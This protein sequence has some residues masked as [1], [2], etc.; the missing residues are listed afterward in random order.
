MGQRLV[1]LGMTKTYRK[2]IS[3]SEEPHNETTDKKSLA[4][5]SRPVL[6]HFSVYDYNYLYH[7]WRSQNLVVSLIIVLVQFLTERKAKGSRS[8]GGILAGIM[9]TSFW[10]SSTTSTS[11]VGT[12]LNL[13]SSV[14]RLPGA[15]RSL[16]FLIGCSYRHKRYLQ[17]VLF[18]AVDFPHGWT[19]K[20]RY[21]MELHMHVII[22]MWATFLPE[23]AK[24]NIHTSKEC[25]DENY[26]CLLAISAERSA[27]HVNVHVFLFFLGS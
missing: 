18:L 13:T 25:T 26:E 22:V 6:D 15:V 8:L 20:R 2:T 16:A 11:L 17:P 23:G 12:I 4:Q 14:E 9:S 3:H 19:R 21:Y 27:N 10:W 5:I 1:L 7:P 24:R